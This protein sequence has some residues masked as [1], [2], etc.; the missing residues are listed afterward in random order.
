MPA[1]Y[2][3]KLAKETGVSVEK[4]EKRWASAKKIA[5]KAGRGDD[6]AYITGIFKKM[7]GESEID[8]LISCVESGE[9]PNKVWD[10]FLDS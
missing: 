5:D 3:A 7:M 10:A 2:V 8:G 6:Y 4:A 9:D 1:D